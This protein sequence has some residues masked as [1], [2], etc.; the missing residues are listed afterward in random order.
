[1]THLDDP[2]NA[3]API[4]GLRWRAGIILGSLVLFALN[5]HISWRL[6]FVTFTKQLQSNEGSFIA[7]SRIM[8]DHPSDLLWWPIWNLGITFHHT[9]FPL[10]HA[11]DSGVSALAGIY[12]ALA[13]PRA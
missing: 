12:P 4:A 2:H 13:V 11:L 3:S 1:M 10:L 5:L 8:R 7:I 6:F 9:D